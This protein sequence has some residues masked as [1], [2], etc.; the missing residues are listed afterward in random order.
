MKRQFISSKTWLFRLSMIVCIF[1]IFDTIHAGV[2]FPHAFSPQQGLIAPVEQPWRQ[3][4]CLN[5]L[6][7]FQPV[8]LPANYDIKNGAPVLSDPI[9]EG[10][11]QTHIRIPSPWNVNAFSRSSRTFPSYPAEWERARMGWLRRHF[12]IP[13]NWEGK[14]LVLH[15]EAIC[16]Y[17]QVLVN[18]QLLAEHFD[19]S[20]PFEVDVTDFVKT[21]A[22]NELLLGIRQASLFCV[23]GKYGKLTYPS[24][25]N[26]N[27]QM[28]GVWQDVFLQALP[29][30]RVDDVAIHPIVDQGLLELVV[31]VRNNT[32]LTQPFQISGKVS[33]WISKA[34]KD[35]ISAP[36]PDW[37]LGNPVLDISAA[38]GSV[39][40]RMTTT[41]TVRVPVSNKLAFWTPDSPNLYGLVLDITQDQ[42]TK[43]RCYERFG[44]RQW[45]IE[46]RNLTL[47]GKPI[48]LLG[49]AGHMLGVQY[50]T[51]RY[52]WSWYHALKTANGNAIRLHATVRPR[53]YLD[54][55]DEM[56]IAILDESDIWASTT[57]INYDVPET[58]FRFGAHIDGMVERDRNHACVFGWSIGN[59]ILSALWWIGVPRDTWEPI[60]EKFADLS[61]RVKALDPTRPWISSDGDGDFHGRLP[62]FV[63]H[64][65]SPNDWLRNAPKDK[66]FGI[67]EGGSMIWGSPAVFSVYNGDRSYENSE[68]MRE[69]IAIECYRYLTEQRKISAYCSIF[70]FTGVSF[71]TLPLGVAD[72]TKPPTADDGI[73]FGPFIEGQPGMQPERLAPN[74]TNFNPGYDPNL[75][76]FETTI[77]YDAIKAAYA[78]GSPEP[79]KWDHFVKTPPLPPPPPATI[80]SAG[81]IGDPNG[82]LKLTLES[83]G[84]AVDIKSSSGVPKLLIIDG[85]TFTAG[86]LS[87]ARE[88]MNAVL[89]KNGT[90]FVWA[91]P[92]NIDNVNSLLPL[93]I[94][95]SSQ[96]GSALLAS[97]EAP[98]TAPLSLASL[99]FQDQSDRIIVRNKISGLLVEKSR[100]LMETNS[101]SRRGG[102]GSNASDRSPVLIASDIDGGKL[103]VTTLLPDV[104]T[105]KRLQL[106]RNLFTDLGVKLSPPKKINDTGF[107]GAG[108]LNEALV[109]GSFQGETY[110]KILDR[111]FLG[112]EAQVN[113]KPGDKTGDRI[114]KVVSPPGDGTFDFLHMQLAGTEGTA[115]PNAPIGTNLRPEALDGN[116][117]LEGPERLT[118]HTPGAYSVAYLS[119]WLYSPQTIDQSATGADAQ[120]ISLLVVADDGKKIWLNQN[121]I[122]NDNRI[123]GPGVTNSARIPLTLNK[124]WNHFIVKAG[125]QDGYWKFSARLEC[126]D[127]DLLRKM[128]ADII[129]GQN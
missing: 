103:M 100:I 98:E 7:D 41:I 91:S 6:W 97:R 1:P 74:S 127:A 128:K 111:D 99:Y 47:N 54:L 50:L 94:S 39:G 118:I 121:Q 13:A 129:P 59:E 113:P 125:T 21:G 49:D 66:P 12:S 42:E 33:P 60:I 72:R 101:V 27:M 31:R 57:D 124:G 62:A 117:Y 122:A 81:F 95:L 29:P 2:L 71:T 67:G 87:S 80:T 36:E 51:S 11:S 76:L 119:F 40:P 5:G 55:A 65:G 116:G 44:W 38:S 17:V 75:P 32:S 43:D 104:R 90:V 73:V 37:T 30:L 52:A 114:W 45:N 84:L 28:I 4:I 35:I 14:R 110:P 10:W 123:C 15:F 58:W 26:W 120:K 105:E 92:E 9:P 77:V 79:C 16:G 126:S 69:G 48:T 18:G 20:L 93:P 85:A 64:Y 112:G 24:G 107:D 115:N 61:N 63:Y 22:D 86:Q 8:A 83:S 70:T 25:S 88:L 106:M 82:A 46:G 23:P 108:F 53:F 68:G 96:Q 19:N 102:S 78:P 56:G 109:I 3:E 34:G 89:K